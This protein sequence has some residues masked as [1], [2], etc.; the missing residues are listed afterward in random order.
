MFIYMNI[1]FISS[2][3]HRCFLMD[4]LTIWIREALYCVSR[5]SSTVLGG[6]LGC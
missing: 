4:N 6:L 1:N 5:V 2:V 3:L